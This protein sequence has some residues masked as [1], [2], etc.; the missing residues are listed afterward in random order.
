MSL[1]Q[2]VQQYSHVGWQ[3][4]LVGGGGHFICWKENISYSKLNTH[5]CQFNLSIFQIKNFT[6]MEN[7]V[8]TIQ[9]LMVNLR[10]QNK[11]G[12]KSEQ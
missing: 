9:F 5:A 2:A 7:W 6:Y 3:Q 12:K 8:M 4:W 10:I 11:K 1:I